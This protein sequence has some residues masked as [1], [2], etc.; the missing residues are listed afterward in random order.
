MDLTVCPT[1][2]TTTIID[3]DS[4]QDYQFHPPQVTPHTN[5]VTIQGFRNS[6][7]PTGRWYNS[8]QG[9]VISITVKFVL[10]YGEKLRG[11]Q[12][13][14]LRSQNT[15]LGHPGHHVHQFAPTTINHEI[16]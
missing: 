9:G 12:E 4:L 6:Y 13:E 8:Y 14:Q 3:F 11:I 16:V 10:Q 5:P 7:P 2:T 1:T 15:A